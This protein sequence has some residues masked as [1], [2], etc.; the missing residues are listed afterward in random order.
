MA[1][2]QNFRNGSDI[3]SGKDTADG[4]AGYPAFVPT[5]V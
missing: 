5:A 4:P 2:P 3:S 1:R